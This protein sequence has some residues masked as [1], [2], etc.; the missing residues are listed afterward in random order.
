MLMS[1]PTMAAS[2][3]PWRIRVVVALEVIVDLRMVLATGST[4]GSGQ[5]FLRPGAVVRLLMMAILGG[6]TLA[7]RRWARW[8]FAAL[9][10]VTAIAAL[11]LG[12]YSFTGRPHLAISPATLAAAALYGIA[13]L[14]IIYPVKD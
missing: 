6:Y 5:T 11:V 14:G 8:C 4:F 3:V 12:L 9:L 7:G 13:F 2:L 1:A 10:A